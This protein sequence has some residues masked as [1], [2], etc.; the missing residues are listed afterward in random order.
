MKKLYE[1][2]RTLLSA[3]EIWQMLGRYL[4]SFMVSMLNYLAYNCLIDI[5]SVFLPQEKGNIDV[6]IRYYLI[7]IEV[8]YINRSGYSCG[9]NLSL[10][11]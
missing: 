7:A 9:V 2:T 3:M 6:A 8:C 4:A 10:T 1:L 5:T 11:V